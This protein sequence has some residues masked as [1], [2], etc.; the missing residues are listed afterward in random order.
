MIRAFV[1]SGRDYCNAGVWVSSGHNSLVTLADFLAIASLALSQH[2]FHLADKISHS[3]M[4]FR[5]AA[6]PR[7]SKCFY[8]DTPQAV[9]LDQSYMPHASSAL[10][11]ATLSSDVLAA[12]SQ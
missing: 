8:R 12:V 6:V 2:I 3:L 5:Q 9:D 11:Y 1:V 4:S 7:L 10:S